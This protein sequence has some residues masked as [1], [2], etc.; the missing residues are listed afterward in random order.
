M[1][2]ILGT[3]CGGYGL[4]LNEAHY[5]IFYNNGFKF[6]ERIQKEDRNHRIGQVHKVVYIDLVCEKSIDERIMSALDS[7]GDVVEEF[8]REVD[9]IKDRKERLKKLVETL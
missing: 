3:A 9:K 2:D 5:V 7:K 1:P 8:K 4:T 6:A